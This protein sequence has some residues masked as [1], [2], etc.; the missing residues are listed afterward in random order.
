MRRNR[1]IFLCIWILSVVG[2]SFYGGPISYGFFYLA[3][4]VP[5]VSLV[6]LIAVLLTFKIYQNLDNRYPVSNRKIPFYFT[7]QNETFFEFVNIKVSFFAEYSTIE[8][9]CEDTQYA[10]RPHEGIKL[11]TNLVCKYRGEYEVGIK[12]VR[13]EDFFGLFAFSYRNPETVKVFVRPNLIYLDDIRNADIMSV[14]EKNSAFNA[15]R[16]DVL[17]RDYVNGDERK[18]INWKQSAKSQSLKVHNLITEQQ[19]GIGIIVDTLRAKSDPAYYLPRENKIME[20]VLALSYYLASRRIAHTAYYIAPSLKEFEISE[21]SSFDAF[22][23]EM[24]QLLFDASYDCATLSSQ[25]AMRKS[26]FDKKLIFMVVDEWDE[27]V[28]GLASLLNENG[29]SITAYVL[30]AGD[31]ENVPRNLPLTKIVPVNLDDKLDRVL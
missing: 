22:Y 14:S 11:S 26:V 19:E 4:L 25:L 27:H 29:I 13:I 17:V 12:S 15:A 2:I 30:A 24:S 7:L 8:G 20:T 23:E 10:L 21:H 1:L 9:M 31:D 28:Y 5:V 16:K 6:Y 3:T 18:Y